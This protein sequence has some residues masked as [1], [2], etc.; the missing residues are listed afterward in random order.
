MHLHSIVA[1][2]RLAWVF[3][4]SPRLVP[5]HWH[6]VFVIVV[7]APLVIVVVFDSEKVESDIARYWAEREPLRAGLHS[8]WNCWS[9]TA[10]SRIPK[11]RSIVVRVDFG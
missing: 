4:E 7:E 2:P 9:W 6:A 1:C 11:P 10:S 8:G 3:C 5:Q